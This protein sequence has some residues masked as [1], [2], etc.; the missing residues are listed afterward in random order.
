LVERY[1]LRE[2]SGGPGRVR[3]GTG[4]S[5]SV[6]MLAA[7]SIVTARGLER[8]AFQPWGREGGR[9]GANGRSFL[10]DRSGASEE[11]GKIDVL[12]LEAGSVISFETAG[13]GGFGHPYE[14]DPALVLRDVEDGL[15]SVASAGQDYGV[16]LRDGAVDASATAQRREESRGRSDRFAFGSERERYDAR[17]S[18]EVQSGIAAIAAA[19]PPIFRQPLRLGLLADL[20]A[21]APPEDPAGLAGWLRER[22][23]GIL[24][25]LTPYSGKT[26]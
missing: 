10:E 5:Y 12:G 25:G 3:G 16:V 2:D 9:P 24:A 15:V 13:G 21:A 19:A 22:A 8:F 1:G 18:D 6:R 23:D 26:G 11:I 20:E 4:L 7:G 14:R 17:W